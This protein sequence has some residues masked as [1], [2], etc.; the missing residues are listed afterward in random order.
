MGS[1]KSNLLTD[2]ISPALLDT[3]KL[4]LSR[5]QV[6]VGALAAGVAGC[7][8]ADAAESVTEVTFPRL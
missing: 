6:L 7:T 3:T 2:G 5:R 1:K 4:D 8:G